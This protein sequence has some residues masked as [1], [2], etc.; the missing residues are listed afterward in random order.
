ME[1][2]GTNGKLKLPK[3]DIN[4]GNSGTLMRFIVGFS[5]LVKGKT[6][7]TGSKRIQQRPIIDL[8]NSLN[9]LPKSMYKWFYHYRK[10]TV[11]GTSQTVV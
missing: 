11:P 9:D 5:S 8:L 6:K 1:I 7:I 3:D 2:N 4:V 10:A